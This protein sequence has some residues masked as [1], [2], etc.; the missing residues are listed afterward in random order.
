[1]IV[2]IVGVV[3]FETLVRKAGVPSRLI[4]W[5]VQ[6]LVRHWLY[7][8]ASSLFRSTN[9]NLTLLGSTPTYLMHHQLIEYFVAVFT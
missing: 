6:P 9:A 7:R 8:S 3:Y 4:T 2:K 5:P 1:M